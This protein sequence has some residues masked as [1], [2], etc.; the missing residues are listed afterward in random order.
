MTCLF[1][2]ERMGVRWRGKAGRVNR[3]KK[4]ECWQE[5]GGGYREINKDV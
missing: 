5:L 3:D 2:T 4:E 1:E